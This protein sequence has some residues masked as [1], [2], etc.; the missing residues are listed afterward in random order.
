[1]VFFASVVN[2]I[3][4]FVTSF[5][6]WPLVDTLGL[7]YLIEC[8]VLFLF[9]GLIDMSTSVSFQGFRRRILKDSTLPSREAIKSERETA[10]SILI[11]GGILLTIT[12]LLTLPYL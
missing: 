8:S 10:V 11:A 5:A 9:A 6:N 7:L 12:G 2:L 3:I 4:A 1:M